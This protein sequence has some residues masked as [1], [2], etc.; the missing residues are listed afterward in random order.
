MSANMEKVDTYQPIGPNDQ[1]VKILRAFHTHL[2][3]DCRVNFLYHL[4]SLETSQQLQD[5]ANSL[6]NGLVAP[7]MSLR[8]TPSV[9]PRLR[10]DHSIDSIASQSP[11]P[12]VREDPLKKEYLACDGNRCVLTGFIDFPTLDKNSTSEQWIQI[13]HTSYHFLLHPENQSQSLKAMKKTLSGPTSSVIS[14]NSSQSILVVRISATP[15]P[16]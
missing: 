15:K 1:T 10:I 5:I 13:V 4:E 6:I 8:S 12:M 14:Q 11:G 2:P 9:S 3:A 7:I 16:Q